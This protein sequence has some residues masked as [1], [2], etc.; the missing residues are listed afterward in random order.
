MGV[1][2]KTIADSL[3]MNVIP[4]KIMLATASNAGH[5]STRSGKGPSGVNSGGYINEAS[6]LMQAV[7]SQLQTPHN[8]GN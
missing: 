5:L 2:K 8:Q 7:S 3:A 4:Q 6:L 1:S